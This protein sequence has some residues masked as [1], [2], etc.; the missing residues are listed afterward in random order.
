MSRLLDISRVDKP[1]S[2][3]KPQI[4]DITRTGRQQFEGE[5]NRRGRPLRTIEPSHQE[6]KEE[7]QLILRLSSAAH[8]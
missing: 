5:K 4:R 1:Q 2:K 3:L 6:V 8:P 7:I